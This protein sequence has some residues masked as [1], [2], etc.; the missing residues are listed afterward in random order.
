MC[1]HDSKHTAHNSG[2]QK[3]RPRSTQ[4]PTAK[5]TDAHHDEEHSNWNRRSFLQAL[6][7]VGGGTMMVGGTNLTAS[8]PTKLTAALAA[9]EVSDR[10]LVLVRLKGGND[11]LNTIVPLYDYDFYANK[12]PSIRHQEADLY[13]LS[14]DIGIPPSLEELQSLWG[15][16]AMKVVHGVGY[17]NQN[18]SHFRSSDIWASGVSDEI[19]STGVFGRYFENIYP[20]YLVNPPAEP[21]AIQIGTQSNLILDGLNSTYGFSVVNPEQLESIAETGVLH[22]VLDVP[23]CTYGEQL[24]FMRAIKNTTVTYAGV[25]HD[26]YDASTNATEYTGNSLGNQLSL[27]ARMI[28]GGLNTKVYLVTLGGFDTHASQEDYHNML[29]N[30]IASNMK[31]FYEDLED[32]GMQDRVL[33]MTFSEFGRRIEENGSQGTDHGAASPIMLFGP[34]L[35]GNGFVGEHPDMQNPDNVGNLAYGI[36]FRSVYKTVLQDWLCIEPTIIDEV[37]YGEDYPSLDLGFSCESLSTP[38]FELTA[39]FKHLG[40]YQNGQTFVEFNLPTTAKVTV[41][42]YNILGQEVGTL[43]NDFM[44]EGPQKINVKQAINKRLFTGQYFYRITFGGRNYS[45]SILI[46]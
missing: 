29:M 7:L 44:F 24:E 27:V 14:S 45:K 38:D 46:S 39:G 4:G 23:G 3:N 1:N 6:G 11:G 17:E 8:A 42:L 12:R 28:K 30:E 26:A 2:N 31:S 19:D 34:A 22:D 20:D 16:G 33:S 21:A 18:L 41:S 10:I 40:T 37:F 35:E 25:I 15:D 43:A 36:D 13:Q 32:A 5:I 9:S